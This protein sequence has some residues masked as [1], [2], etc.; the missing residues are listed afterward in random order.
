MA[1]LE[2]FVIHNT[3]KGKRFEREVCSVARDYGLTA[4]RTPRSGATSFVKGDVVIDT[5][6]TSLTGECKRRNKL[7]KFIV[8]SLADH[9]FLAMRGDRGEA[10]VV[11]RLEEYMSLVRRK[12]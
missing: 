4:R 3:N 9:D 5:G 2:E 12:L 8:E 11:I 7:S 10:L 1:V 6:D